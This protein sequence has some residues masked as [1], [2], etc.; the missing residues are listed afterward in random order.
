MELLE[1][2]HYN[3]N[4]QNKLV[5]EL[6]QLVIDDINSKECNV[7]E[8]TQRNIYIALGVS[9]GYTEYKTKELTNILGISK[10]SLKFMTNILI[11]EGKIELIKENNITFLRPIF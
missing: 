6:L 7:E 5:S 4:Q 3:Y 9:K 2:V 1:Y 8:S 10:T 11:D